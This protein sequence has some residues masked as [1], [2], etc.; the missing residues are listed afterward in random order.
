METALASQAEFQPSHPAIIVFVIIAKKV[1]QTMKGEHPKLSLHRVP[2]FDR[3]T[4]CNPSRDHDIAE[5]A[6]LA[7]GK[8]QDVGCAIFPTKT[9]VEGAYAG[10]GDHRDGDRSAGA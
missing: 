8:R 3:L 10:I 1:Q 9:A 2:R 7:C 5:S 6:R 4:G